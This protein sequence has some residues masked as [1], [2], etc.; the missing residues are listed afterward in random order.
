MHGILALFFIK[1][2]IM[3]RAIILLAL[4]SVS[5]S[6]VPG[7]KPYRMDVQQGN[8]VNSKMMAQLRPGMTKSQ[9][10]FILGTPLIQDSFHK[11]R[12]DYFYQMRKGGAVVEQRRVILDFENDVLKGVRGDVIPATPDTE[13][14]E[15]D[16][17][18]A[19]KAE[20]KKGLADKLKF[21]ESDK[22]G[23]QSAAS[24]VDAGKHAVVA[25]PADLLPATASASTATLVAP[26][27]ESTVAKVPVASEPAVSQP[28][29]E[30]LIAPPV[31]ADEP[32][33]ADDSQLIEVT[34]NAWA[35][36]WRNKDVNT[37]LE[38]YS[39]KF[40]PEGLPS[41]KAWIAQRKQ[42]LS[43]SGKITLA[44]DDVDVKVTGDKATAQF[45][46][47]YSS[48][49]YKDNVNK[50][51]QFERAGDAWLIT[52]ENTA[53]PN[54][55]RPA[56]V[57]VKPIAQDEIAP[58]QVNN[59]QVSNV[60]ATSA[61]K[62][63][64]DAIGTDEAIISRVNAWADAWRSKDINGYLSFYGEKFVPD[65]AGSKK[66]WAAQRKQRLSK[67]GE[68]S[69]QLDG[70]KVN[71]QGSKATV[72]FVQ[73]YSSS[74]FSDNVTKTLQMQLVDGHWVIVRESVGSTLKKI[75]SGAVNED[76]A[77]T[78]KL[79]PEQKS[80]FMPEP[81]PPAVKTYP[82]PVA[83]PVEP[84][85]AQV[86]PISQAAPAAATSQQK[87][88][89]TEGKTSADNPE[90]EE[91]PGLFERMLEKIGF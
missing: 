74:G 45:M 34:L 41:K 40:V 14:K 90:A 91:K 53:A 38:F 7:L 13:A 5:C 86:E 60:E 27:E 51:L 78:P 20:E 32:A 35:Q 70:I 55:N 43:K 48:N 66:A 58:I 85:P 28:P 16:A 67:P 79:T 39:D 75:P 24:N 31:T 88:K 21:W 23:E 50:I 12:W 81:V 29:A 3:R 15:K 83:A 56:D 84:E 72:D 46:Q 47:H 73:R 4:F 80:E 37:Y 10:R 1:V 18:V 82:E 87:L 64:A 63:D 11:D 57:T 52:R 19:P 54:L 77:L 61:G 22:S 26:V 59:V 71:S 44:L 36:A 25:V 49:G 8:V 62:T 42:R 9:V 6:S 33:K 30:T 89:E 17:T 69:L 76:A 68:I 2:M 65:S